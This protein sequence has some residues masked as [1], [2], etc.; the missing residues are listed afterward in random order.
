M[1]WFQR[2][3]ADPGTPALTIR[4]A[5]VV[6]LP[7]C[8]RGAP[9]YRAWRRSS[10]T[11]TR[12]LTNRRPADRSTI[13]LRHGIEQTAPEIFGRSTVG[14]HVKCRDA[15]LIGS[16]DDRAHLRQR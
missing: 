10:S 2:A 11:L 6:F 7:D 13:E 14:E 12:Q 3:H 4:A 8:R 5:S 9:P 16:Y 1:W 15:A